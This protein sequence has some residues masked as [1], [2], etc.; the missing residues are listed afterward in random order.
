MT[1]AERRAAFRKLHESGCFLIPNP[2][3]AAGAMRLEKMGFKALAS[4]SS[5]AAW[6]RGKQDGELTVDEVLGHLRDLVAATDLPINADFEQGFAD[7]PADVAVNVARAVDTGVA[8]LSIED[9]DGSKIY[10]VAFAAERIA[11]AKAAVGDSGALL[12]GRAEG[13]LRGVA[14]LEDVIARLRAYSAAGADVLFA[15]GVRDLDQIRELVAA[16]AP[17]PL[18]VIVSKPGLR[19]ADL[20]DIG[21]RRIST[22]GALAWAAW[23]AF[24]AA[25]LQLRD[26]G[27]FG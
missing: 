9:W 2:G 1:I 21:V 25:A 16:V 13:V 11:A 22:G 12:V 4:S 7:A 26:S 10:D 15:P 8:G 19:V 3:D 27:T 6:A 14:G 17:K 18:N 20:A 23:Q 5:A 24:D